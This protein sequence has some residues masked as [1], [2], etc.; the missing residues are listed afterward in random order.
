MIQRLFYSL[1][2][3][4]LKIKW[5]CF[6][7]YICISL[8]TNVKAF[9]QAEAQYVKLNWTELFGMGQYFIFKV[10]MLLH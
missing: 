6:I 5:N 8:I 2:F 4:N 10:A 1:I 9:V 3:A 7:V